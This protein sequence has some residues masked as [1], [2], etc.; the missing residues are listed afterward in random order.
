MSKARV[1][2][3]TT[4]GKIKAI[5]INKLRQAMKCR[6]SSYFRS[7]HKH[8]VSVAVGKSIAPWKNLWCC[9]VRQYSILS[10]PETTFPE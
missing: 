7:S 9:T 4:V 1:S 8:G 5:G 10:H 6:I 3:E 2:H